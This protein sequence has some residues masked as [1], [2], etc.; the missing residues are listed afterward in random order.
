M[1]VTATVWTLLPPIIASIRAA[2]ELPFDEGAKR[3]REIFLKL[4]AGPQNEALR[5]VF[6]AEREAAKVPGLETAAARTIATAGVVGSCHA[7]NPQEGRDTD[8]DRADD[9]A[10]GL[11]PP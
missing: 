8:R 7:R 2:T 9:G 5:H 11:R 6:F 3:E 1:D 4:R 10:D